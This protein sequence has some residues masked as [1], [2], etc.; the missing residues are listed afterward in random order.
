MQR[1]TFISDEEKNVMEAID[2]MARLVEKLP[3]AKKRIHQ[4][5]VLVVK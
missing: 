1:K 2:I 4:V 3:A 5:E